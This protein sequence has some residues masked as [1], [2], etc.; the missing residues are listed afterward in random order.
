[1]VVGLSVQVQPVGNGD[2][3]VVV[4][5]ASHSDSAW[6]DMALRRC[7]RMRAA[8]RADEGK[9]VSVSVEEEEEIEL[10]DMVLVRRV[11]VGME[12]RKRQIG[13]RR[14][15]EIINP[16]WAINDWHFL[17][18]IGKRPSPDHRVVYHGRCPKKI[19]LG[20]TTLTSHQ[21]VHTIPS[22]KSPPF[23]PSD[24]I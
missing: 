22:N 19:G 10:D 15:E 8:A 13:Q 3:A 23:F 14:G 6:R 9:L 24:L 4:G 5:G 16:V 20:T 21:S 12:R 18:T 7:L 11:V 2:G 17:R 1:M